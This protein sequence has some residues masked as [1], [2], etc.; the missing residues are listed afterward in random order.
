M[1]MEERTIKRLLILVAAC[2]IA[3]M[4]FKMVLTRSY[5]ALNKAAAEKKQAATVRPAEPQ[6]APTPISAVEVIDTPAAASVSEAAA[7]NLPAAS[8]VSETQ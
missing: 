4:F 1:T 7:A 6:P 8:G 2:I 3:I 5:T